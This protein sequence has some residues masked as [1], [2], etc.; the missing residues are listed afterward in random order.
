M[1]RELNPWVRSRTSVLMRGWCSA[2]AGPIMEPLARPRHIGPHSRFPPNFKLM[3]DPR[4]DGREPCDARDVTSARISVTPRPRASPHAGTSDHLFTV[5]NR[6]SA[7][8][9][10]IPRHPTHPAR[11]PYLTRISRV[12]TSKRNQPRLRF[13]PSGQLAIH[14]RAVSNDPP[15]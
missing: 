4:R 11:S 10:R 1:L 3:F 7:L 12:V 9:V 15:G 14:G 8:T 5:G 6:L 2:T 13:Q